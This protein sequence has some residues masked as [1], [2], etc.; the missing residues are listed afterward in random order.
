MLRDFGAGEGVAVRE[1]VCWGGD[2]RGGISE[3]VWGEF[4]GS[5]AATNRQY[6]AVVPLA[7]RDVRTGELVGDWVLPPSGTPFYEV[8]A[9][10]AGTY[11]QRSSL[12]MA[13][14]VMGTRVPLGIDIRDF[15]ESGWGD[16]R[17]VGV[18]GRS[19]S[20]K[21]VLAATLAGAYAGQRDLGILLID[22]QG[23]FSS[24]D[25]F[26][27]Y[28][29]EMGKA[30]QKWSWRLSRMFELANRMSDVV[31]AGWDEVRLDEADTDTFLELLDYYKFWPTLR[32]G[33]R[34]TRW[35]LR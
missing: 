13:G 19:G 9:E 24:S 26:G 21:S 27:R 20:G 10:Q 12:F 1:Q 3:P 32:P 22:P 31:V 11:Y 2:K 5:L 16:A 4:A 7:V 17:L 25:E 8:E 14:W 28:A 33:V 30:P 15:G 18:A 23:Q 6:V 34:G 29:G 35:R